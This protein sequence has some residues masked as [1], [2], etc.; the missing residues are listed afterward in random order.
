MHFIAKR[1]DDSIIAV[2]VFLPK[3][4][5]K[6]NSVILGDSPSG[7]LQTAASVSEFLFPSFR[8]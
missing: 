4:V 2:M 5:I 6:E 8:F 7:E 1:R 3:G